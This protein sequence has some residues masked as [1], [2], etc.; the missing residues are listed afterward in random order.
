MNSSITSNVAATRDQVTSDFSQISADMSNISLGAGDGVAT[1]FG[2]MRDTVSGSM[3]ST[4][5]E[6]TSKSQDIKSTMD[7]QLTATETVVKNKFDAMKQAVDEKMVM[8]VTSV[9]SAVEKVKAAFN[10]E[11]KFKSVVVPEFSISGKFDSEAGKVPK[12]IAN[13]KTIYFAEG[14]I[15]D[16]ATIFGMLGNRPMVAGEKGA[17]AIAPIDTLQG[18]V[19]QAVASQNAGLIDVLNR[20]LNAIVNMDENMGENMKDALDGTGLT[21]NRREFGRLVRGTV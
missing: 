1:S 7:S 5:A 6:V 18:Y 15:V 17:E 10:V 8:L 11:L 21:I 12:V 3:T 19:A 16:S 14:G 20:I 13:P 2:N 4:A 9:Q